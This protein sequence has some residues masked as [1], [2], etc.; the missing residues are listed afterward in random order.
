MKNVFTVEDVFAGRLLEVPDYQR[1]YSWEK[2]QLRD[3]IEDLEL[4]GDGKEHYTGTLVLHPH[5]NR[6]S[7]MDS[8]GRSYLS[9]D[10]VDGQQRLTT[11]VLLLDAIR[12]EL[13]SQR[14][15]DSLAEGI[16]TNYLSV[17][18]LSGQPLLRLQLNGD[19]NDYW[20]DEVL[21]ERALGSAATIASHRRL[22]LAHEIFRTVDRGAGTV[23]VGG[24]QGCRR[25]SSAAAEPSTGA[26]RIDD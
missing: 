6:K 8:Q 19:T 5:A 3:F 9:A 26:F 10:I 16:G 1:G 25:R 22:S 18:D 11:I 4:L 7:R 20:R 24:L 21:A 2:E 12:R 14:I 17:K 23:P 15:L 13:N